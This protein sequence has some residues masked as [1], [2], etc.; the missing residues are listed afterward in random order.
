MK[1]VRLSLC[2]LLLALAATAASS[3]AV[4]AAERA[5]ATVNATAHFGTRSTLTVS[6]DVLRFDVTNPAAPAVMTI[7]FAAAVRTKADG[8][9]LLTVEPLRAVE[10]PGSAA[11][12]EAAIDF[13]GDGEGTLAG[14]LD[15]GRPAL[16]GRWTGSGRRT[17]RLQ[18]ALTA[19]TAG[20]YTMPVRFVLS[21]P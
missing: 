2:A 10:G 13:T 20:T 14:P 6:T 18:F 19:R 3:A 12:V 9:V 21:V 4:M 8:E 5:T 11:D 15:A 1:S 7:D 16:A 17:G